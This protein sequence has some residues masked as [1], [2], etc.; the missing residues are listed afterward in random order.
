MTNLTRFFQAIPTWLNWPIAFNGPETSSTEKLLGW[1]PLRSS[2]R[3][4]PTTVLFRT[5][6][7]RI[8]RSHYTN[9]WYSWVQT[10][11]CVTQK[12]KTNEICSQQI[13]L[14]SVKEWFSSECCKS[15]TAVINSSQ[16]RRT[17]F[18]I[19]WLIDWLNTEN[20]RGNVCELVMIEF[21]SWSDLSK[22][23]SKLVVWFY[24][25]ICFRPV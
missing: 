22:N 2:K 17:Q 24:L 8:G 6:L 11:Y 19:D 20:P 5:T 3:Q 10:I 14:K 18:W 23:R 7:T 12:N 15:K 25:H 16:S 9:Y 21:L 4:S 1:L 13:W